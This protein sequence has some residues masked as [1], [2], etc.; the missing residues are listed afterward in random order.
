MQ[1]DTRIREKLTYMNIRGILSFTN[2]VLVFPVGKAVVVIDFADIGKS[3]TDDDREL[4]KVLVGKMSFEGII[5]D[6]CGLENEFPLDTVLV[7]KEIVNWLEIVVA[8]CDI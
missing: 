5:D 1:A 2:I 8:I 4:Y 6:V 7:G 3:V